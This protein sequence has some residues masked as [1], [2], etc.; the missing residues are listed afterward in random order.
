MKDNKINHWPTPAE[1]PDLNPIEMLWSE[2]KQFIRRRV[3]PST[4]EELVNA[5]KTFWTRL[6]VAKCNRYIDHLYKVIPIV[7]E[8]DGRASGH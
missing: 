1:S 3:K 8:R 6:T 7:L 4:K 5:I 2:L